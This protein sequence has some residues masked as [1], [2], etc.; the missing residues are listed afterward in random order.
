M[1]QPHS[2]TTREAEPPTREI[3]MLIQRRDFLGRTAAGMMAL[4]AA[5]PLFLARTA[6]AATGE[7]R[8]AGRALV[9]L[10]LAGGD[11][12][13]NTIIPFSDPEYRKKRHALRPP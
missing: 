2:Q 1:D 11:D 13:L 12:G 4:G 3:V 8:K 5:P 10:E 6:S 7:A 9:V